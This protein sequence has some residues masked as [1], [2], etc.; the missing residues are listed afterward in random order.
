MG[1]LNLTHDWP[2]SINMKAPL[3]F[4][5]TLLGTDPSIDMD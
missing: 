5:C 3:S 4:E 2:V 1:A